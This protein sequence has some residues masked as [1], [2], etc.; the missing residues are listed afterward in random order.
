MIE[1]EKPRI[2]ILELNEEGNYGKFV[3][4]PLERGYGTTLG[5][6]LRRVLLSSLPGAAVSNIKIQGV[7]HEFSTVPGVLEDVP[8]IILNIKGIA[9][10][11]YSEEPVTLLIDVVG[12]KVVTAG[13]I[14]TGLDVEIVNKDHYIATVNEDGRLYVEMELVKGRGYV[15][16]E[17]NKKEGQPIGV[18]PIDSSFT[19]VNKVNFSVENTRVGQIT[20]YD[21]LVLEVWTNGT[22]NADEAT[23]LGAKILTEHLNLFIG[24]TEHVND[25]EIMVEKEEDKKEKVLE[26]TVEE[27]D[28][29]VRSYNCL[30]RAA[31]NTVEEL[32]Q[33]TEEDMMKV[34][35]LGKKSLEEVQRKLAELGLSLKRSDE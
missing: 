24:L 17:K 19:P 7:L 33:K 5:N 16:S 18:I 28:L 27:L 2:E 32:T 9:S 23:S 14:I 8:E 13:D 1:I 29:S 21:K 30:K 4:E 22:M 35:N 11:S 25:V 6:S 3:V 10:K 34:R 20:D 15:V 12:P 26:M 31:I